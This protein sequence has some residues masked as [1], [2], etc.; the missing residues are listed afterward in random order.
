MSRFLISIILFFLIGCGT[1]NSKKISEINEID[2][3]SILNSPMSLDRH[4]METC[5]NLNTSL[6]PFY[7][8]DIMAH[9]NNKTG[10]WKECYFSTMCIYCN[11]LTYEQEPQFQ[12]ALFEYFLH[13]PAEYLAFLDK[14]TFEISDCLLS[15]LSAYVNN[16]VLNDEI[17]LISIKNV[18]YKHCSDCSDHDIE[19]IYLYLDLVKKFQDK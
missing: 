16:H 12:A 19:A 5:Y 4:V 10:L 17:T 11:S 6:L 15:K 14:T 13:N 1:S 9:L 7:L 8:K 2:I 18:V 3:E